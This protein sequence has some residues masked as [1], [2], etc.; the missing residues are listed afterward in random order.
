MKKQACDPV[1][2]RV[3]ELFEESKMTLDE[4]ARKMGY[5][6]QTARTSVWQFL[7]RTNDPRVSMLRKFATALGLPMANLFI[8][9]PDTPAQQECDKE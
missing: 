7:T 8:D 4:M 9:T 3:R 6:G 1:M 5:T 2:A